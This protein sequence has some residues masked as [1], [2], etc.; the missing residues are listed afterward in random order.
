MMFGF[1]GAT[2]T[3]PIDETSLIESNTGY[4]VSPAL[5]RLPDTTGGEARVED[6]GFADRAGHRGD[7][8]AAERA[9]VAPD[10]PGEEVGLDGRDRRAG[11]ECEQECQAE[12]CAGGWMR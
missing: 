1:D 4:Q 11:A 9:D 10:E 3:A 2:S 5:V 7:A 6:P 12:S 8:A